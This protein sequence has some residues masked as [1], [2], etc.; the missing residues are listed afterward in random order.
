MDIWA[1]LNKMLL[2]GVWSWELTQIELQGNK[3]TEIPGRKKGEFPTSCW[4]GLVSVEQNVFK[5]S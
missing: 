5:G 1:F 4:Q 3:H 2:E